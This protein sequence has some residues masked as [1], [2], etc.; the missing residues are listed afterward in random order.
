MNNTT[1]K[2]STAKISIVVPAFNE[3]D[4]I[5]P[6]TERLIKML[7]KYTDY[8]I[9]FIDDG[10]TDQTL[11]RIQKLSDQNQHIKYM[12]F[13]RNFG[14]Q[15]ALKAGLDHASGDCVIS[16]DADLQHPSEL[17]DRMIEK[18]DQGCE[19]V[20]TIRQETKNLPPFKRK[21]AALFY[22]LLNLVSS[23][24]LQSGAADFRLMDRS[25]VEVFKDFNEHHLFVRGL[26]S[27][28]GFKECS[29]EYVPN[30][31]LS[32]R[33]KYS[34]KKMCL[35]ALDGLTSFSV[36]PLHLATVLGL[37]VSLFA[38]LYAIFALIA[39]FVADKLVSG[40]TS[41]IISVLF[42]GGIQLLML[43]ILGEYLGK[44]FIE[45]KKRPNYIIREK[46]L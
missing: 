8:E 27:W 6:L 45:S 29:I 21:S 40:W 25:V 33:S 41:V 7:E 10:S 16:M 22:K 37:I 32:G 24:N 38:F 11:S 39:K 36:K 4:N 14:H 13:S 2:S 23:I 15:K 1:P 3:Q 12:S 46:K 18:W 30:N 31:R 5:A 34:V 44:L 26:V 42:I 20:C 9:L 28:M 19:V 43:G 17:I 35:F